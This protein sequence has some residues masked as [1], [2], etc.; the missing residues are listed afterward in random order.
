MK[1]ESIV[2]NNR[3]NSEAFRE[4]VKVASVLKVKRATA[5]NALVLQ[6]APEFISQLMAACQ[7]KSTESEA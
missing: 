2:L 1:L 5:L 6:K 7:A 4:V 3:N